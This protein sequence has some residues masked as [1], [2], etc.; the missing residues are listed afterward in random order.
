MSVSLDS[1]KLITT[2]EYCELANPVF[3]G[4]T[5]IDENKM[6]FMVFECDGVYYKVHNSLYQYK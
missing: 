4:Q 5:P 2:D 1:C 6:Y 3:I